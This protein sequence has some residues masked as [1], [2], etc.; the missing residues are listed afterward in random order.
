MK[1]PTHLPARAE[2]CLRA[3]VEHGW[4]DRLSIGGAFGLLHYVDYRATNDVDAWWTDA[5]REGDQEQVIRVISEA[6]RPYGAVEIRRWGEVVSIELHQGGRAAFSFQIAYRSA[7][8]EPSQLSPWG[9][10]LIDS[11]SDLIGSKMVALVERG[12]P[13]DFRDIYTIC[14]VSLADPA[15]CWRLWGLRQ[16][17]SESDVDQSRAR[18]AVET[19]L[20]RIIVHR[21]LESIRDADE[22][23]R[24]KELR[25]WYKEEFLGA[26]D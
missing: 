7:Q 4:A 9:G 14:R 16:E 23:A 24:A 20:S 1:K 21:S 19:H 25:R 2:D 11:L 12:A 22:K 6:L 10:F 3:L 26:P 17:A 13:R 18:L 8:L 5:L 15:T